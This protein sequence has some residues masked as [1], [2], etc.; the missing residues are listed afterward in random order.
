MRTR[1]GIPSITLL[2]EKSDYE[3]LLVRLEK[4][5][6][7]GHEPHTVARLLRP[8]LTQFIK[9]FDEPPVMDFWTKICHYNG[10]SG[11]TYIGGWITAFCAWGAE[12]KWMGHDIERIDTP[13]SDEEKE[14]VAHYEAMASDSYVFSIYSAIGEQ[15]TITV[16]G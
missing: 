2:G 3:S 16:G 15:L 6:T 4:L 14:Y 5:A 13:L 9:A 10:G 8:I 7:L 11:S 1:C 12:G